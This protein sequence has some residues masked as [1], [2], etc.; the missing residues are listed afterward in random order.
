[1]S[2]ERVPPASRE[3]KHSTLGG[4][5]EVL[6]RERKQLIEEEKRRK[7]GCILEGALGGAIICGRGGGKIWHQDALTNRTERKSS[8]ELEEMYLGKKGSARK[9][10]ASSRKDLSL[11]GQI[12]RNS[13]LRP[14]EKL[15]DL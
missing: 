6:R 11:I 7:A 8:F 15:S 4:M 14:E 3:K 13:L 12:Q 2:E 1:V 9:T 10:S 5:R